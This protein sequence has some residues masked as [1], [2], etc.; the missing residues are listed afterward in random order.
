MKQITL[1]IILLLYLSKV[2]CLWC[3]CQEYASSQPCCEGIMNADTFLTINGYS[4]DVGSSYD[5]QQRYKQCCNGLGSL[6][7]CG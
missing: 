2:N 7:F 5:K 6:G 3:H 1:Y 4:C